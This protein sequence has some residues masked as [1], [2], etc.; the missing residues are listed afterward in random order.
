MNMIK[1]ECVT[2]D[3]IWDFRKECNKKLDDGWVVIPATIKISICGFKLD[4]SPYIK[5]LCVA[6]FEKNTTLKTGN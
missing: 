2:S 3:N 1:Q 4:N 5:V 6:F